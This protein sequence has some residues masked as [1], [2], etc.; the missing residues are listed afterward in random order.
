VT[1]FISTSSC[2]LSNTSL[3]FAQMLIRHTLLSPLKTNL[4][5]AHSTATPL[6]EL[7]EYELKPGKVVEYLEQYQQTQMS[8]MPLRLFCL[9]DTGGKL[10]IATHAY[11]YKEG[12]QERDACANHVSN[13][14]GT[15]DGDISCIRSQN[16]SLFVESPLVNKFAGIQG[17]SSVPEEGNLVGNCPIFEV[18]RYHLILGYNTVPK[19]MDLYESGLPSKLAAQDP[20]TALITLLYSEVGRLNEVIEIWRHG[21]GTSAM[22][23]SRVAAREAGP[24][25]ATISKIAPLATKFTNTIHKPTL[26]SPLR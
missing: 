18:R 26:F 14:T 4:V 10:N 15:E 12:H 20:S 23:R 3:R 8:G 1:F 19:F 16:S 17:L 9:P 6:V 11:Y 25:R 21:D 5:R 24:W 2:F 7:R 22:E 13:K